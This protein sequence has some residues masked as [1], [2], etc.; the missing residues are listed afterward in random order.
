[1]FEEIIDIRDSSGKRHCLSHI[2]EQS[3][4]GILNKKI[5]LIKDKGGEFV[6]PIKMNNK[7][8]NKD[9]ID[10]FSYAI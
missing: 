4:C 10:F 9:M 2:M 3:I 8:A 1:M 6:L 7:G 5:N